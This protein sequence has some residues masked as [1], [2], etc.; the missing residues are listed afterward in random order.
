MPLDLR[1]LLSAP[2]AVPLSFSADG[3][4]LLLRSDASGSMQLY[5][6]SVEGGELRQLTDLAEPATGLFL[7]DGRVL[8]ETDTGGNERTQL[9]LLGDDGELEPLV[10]DERF[11]HATPVVDPRGEVLAYATNRRNGVDFD[12]AVRNLATGE[13]HLF[14][15]GGYS[16]VAGISPDARFVVALRLGALSGDSDLYL[17]DRSTGELE[18]VTPHEPPAEYDAVVWSADSTSFLTTGDEGREHAAIERYDLATRAWT[19]VAEDSWDLTVAG[20]AAGRTVVE[21]A[22]VDGYSRLRCLGGAEI[23]LPEPG[24]VE[25]VVCSP[26]GRRVAF[27]FS[28]AVDPDAVYVYDLEQRSLAKL[29]H[30]PNV[31]PQ[32]LR[33]P[34]LHRFSSFDGEE[35]PVFLFTPDGE[36]PFPVV[37]TVHGGPESQWRPKWLPSFAPLTQY[38]LSRGYAVAAPNVR[39][40]RGYGKRFVHL[41]D[42]RLRGDSVADLASLHTWLDGRPEIDASRAALYGRSYGGFMVLAGLAFQPELWAAGIEAVGLA[43][44]VTFLERTSAYRRAAREREYGSLEHDREFLLEISPGNH[45]ERIRAPLLVQHGRNDP[46]VPV[47]E[48]ETIHRQLTERG[49]RCELVIYEDEGHMVTKRP[50]RIDFFTRAADFL[51]EVLG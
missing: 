3:S 6:A 32:Q 8:V 14:E 9:Y 2:L 43:N 48:S 39:G 24:V 25:F 26:D 29:T 34:T 41:D 50:N 19:P 23:A 44:L 45:V 22:N 17:L 15:L 49:I 30:F 33:R 51:D 42:V 46:R 38:L 27:A 5:T 36:G 10:V 12:I 11:M 7:P 1:E 20:D 28:S 16:F 37:V 31:A 18:H 35:I 21:L 40:S 4:T 47:F 13:E